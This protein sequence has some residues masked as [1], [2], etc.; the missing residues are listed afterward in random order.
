MARASVAYAPRSPGG[1]ALYRVVQTHFET[2]RA[3][4]ASLRDGQ[5]LP[6]FV[7]Q[8]FRD[9][10]RCGWLAGGFARFRCRGCGL[11]MIEMLRDRTEQKL[12][13]ARLH[14]DELAAVPSGNGDDFERAHLEAALAQLLGAFDALLSEM[15]VTLGCNRDPTDVS[16]GKLRESMK[17]QGRTS[18]VLSR[19]YE[20]PSDDESWLRQLHQPTV[21]DAESVYLS[22]HPPRAARLHA[23]ME[24]A[25][26]W[27]RGSRPAL[28]GVIGGQDFANLMY[29]VGLA[30]CERPEDADS[31]L[32]NAFIRS[33]E[34]PEYV[35]RLL[36]NLELHKS[37]MGE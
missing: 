24:H 16:L 17:A 20:L 18:P 26:M 27:C 35:E 14:L 36:G 33:P 8:A 28:V 4:A 1:E 13:F 29:V 31:S 19:I 30:V 3:Q 10:L 21:P 11:D 5:G 15:N 37:L 9:Y 22:T 32:Q 23:Y 2:F 6:R 25:M 12:R 7:E 34:G